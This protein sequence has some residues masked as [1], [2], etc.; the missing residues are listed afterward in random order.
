MRSMT[1]EPHNPSK[2]PPG[3]PVPSDDGACV[4]LA[5]AALPAISLASTGGARVELSALNSP[6]VLFFYPRTGVPGQP[7]SPGFAGEEWDSIPGARGCTPQSCGFRDLH[8]RFAAL[9]VRVYGVSTNTTEHQREFKARNHVPFEF[10]SD[11]ELRLTRAM[12]LPT[13]EFPVES[14]GPT[15]L[16]K[17][18]AWYVEPDSLGAPRI[19]KVWY[20]VFPPDQN[21][22]TVLAWLTRRAAVHIRPRG[23]SDDAFVREE[24]EKHWHQT[25]IWSIGRAFEADR[26]PAF[27]AEMD[28]PGGRERVGLVT[29]DVNHGAYQCE[30]VTVSSR[31]EDAGV[32]TRLLESVEN[33]ARLARCSRVFLTMTNDNVKAFGFYQRRGWKLAALHRGN[34]EEARKRK[35]V[36]PRIG[37]FGIEVRDELELELWLE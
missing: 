7:P 23:A 12:K 36:I 32:A 29:Y 26:L 25:R 15:T 27:V 14:G 8:S 5:R 24:L 17:R 13:F 6:T 2:L 35:A 16:L 3:L 9:G 37:L 30:V 19:A 1:V 4:H 10:L 28:S 31:R 18:M 21:A 33:A 34:V 11:S 22:A 20:P